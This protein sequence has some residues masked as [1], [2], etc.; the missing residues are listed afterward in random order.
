MA[1]MKEGSI[2]CQEVYVSLVGVYRAG[3]D[4]PTSAVYAQFL[5]IRSPIIF[6]ALKQDCQAEKESEKM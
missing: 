5:Q 2:Q 4:I 1:E 3:E 6:T